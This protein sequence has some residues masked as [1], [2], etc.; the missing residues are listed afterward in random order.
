MVDGAG[1]I[2]AD[3]TG[4]AATVAENRRDGKKVDLAL[5]SLQGL[6]LSSRTC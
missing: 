2:D 4:H 5:R 3:G 1:V 6:L